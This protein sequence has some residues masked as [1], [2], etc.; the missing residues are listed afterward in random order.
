MRNTGPALL[1]QKD[2][3]NLCKNDVNDWQ[4]RGTNHLGEPE[5]SAEAPGYHTHQRNTTLLSPQA[6]LLIPRLKRTCEP[7]N[8]TL[9]QGNAAAASSAPRMIRRG[10]PDP[11]SPFQQGF[12]WVMRP[13]RETPAGGDRA[14]APRPPASTWCCRP[15]L[16]TIRPAL[17]AAAGLAALAAPLGSA[18]RRGAVPAPSRPPGA[19]A[20]R[21]P[22]RC[23]AGDRR[24]PRPR[25]CSLCPGVAPN[26]PG[27]DT[28][29]SP[30]PVHPGPAGQPRAPDPSAPFRS[31]PRKRGA[32]WT[33]LSAPLSCSLCKS[34]YL[35]FKQQNNYGF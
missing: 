8:D 11:R 3:P 12:L 1:F 29:G 20:E 24:S 2:N 26:A 13:G 9:P 5:N 6:A 16:A 15:G 14:G 21:R 17:R 33:M 7:R 23:P 35:L 31:S 27:G 4:F 30:R 25:G 19:G 34:F 28:R 32:P 10:C 18:Q 22:G